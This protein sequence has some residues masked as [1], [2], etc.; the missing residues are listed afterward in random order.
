MMD[1]GIRISDESPVMNTEIVT[2]IRLD[3]LASV[4]HSI[5]GSG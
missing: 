5:L 3:G 4:A 1:A 2:A